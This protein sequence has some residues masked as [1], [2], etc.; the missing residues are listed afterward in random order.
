MVHSAV[1]HGKKK[2]LAVNTSNNININN[3]CC[4]FAEKH[5]SIWCTDN[6]AFLSHQHLCCCTSVV[7][8]KE[9]KLCH[10]GA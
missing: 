5:D 7:I 6:R 10:N 2:K 1:H 4:L 9:K 8:I 3:L